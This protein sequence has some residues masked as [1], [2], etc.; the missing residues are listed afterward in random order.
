VAR[1]FG[2]ELNKATEY[3]SGGFAGHAGPS[4]TN[5]ANVNIGNLYTVDADE[6]VRK[7]RTSQADALAVAGITLNGA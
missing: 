4:T 7:I 5:S 3:A 6:A 2:F 1:D